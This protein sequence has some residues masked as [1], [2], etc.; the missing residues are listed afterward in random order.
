MSKHRLKILS[1]LLRVVQLATELLIPSDT[2]ALAVDQHHLIEMWTTYI[3]QNFLV[4]TLKKEKNVKLFVKIYIIQP[5]EAKIL[6]F[7]KVI[8]IKITNETFYILF[9]Y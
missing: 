1:T 9:L 6:S 5:T 4:A 3:I 7:Q 2:I 8:S